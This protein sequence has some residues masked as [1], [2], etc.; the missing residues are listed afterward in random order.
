MTSQFND[1]RAGMRYVFVSMIQQ[2]A[3][4]P[5]G[6]GGALTDIK[7]AAMAHL[8]WTAL[9]WIEDLEVWKRKA[10]EAGKLPGSAQAFARYSAVIA[11]LRKAKML[12]T[13]ETPYDDS[14]I[15]GAPDA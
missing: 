13:G 5:A 14:P 8:E 9:P 2:I 3:L 11:G 10:D 1:G 7:R 6:P 12:D 4:L 15:P